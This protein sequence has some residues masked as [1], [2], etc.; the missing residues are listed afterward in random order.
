MW[1]RIATQGRIISRIEDLEKRLLELIQ[2]STVKFRGK[3]MLNFTTLNNFLTPDIYPYVNKIFPMRMGD[4]IA[5]FQPR[6]KTLYLP[7]QYE[8]DLFKALIHEFVHAI[9][10]QDIPNL[11]FQKVSFFDY[12]KPIDL[13][14]S[15]EYFLPTDYPRF[16]E[17]IINQYQKIKDDYY[18][19]CDNNKNLDN[20]ESLKQFPKSN[21]GLKY[22]HLFDSYKEPTEEQWELA[23]RISNRI[24]P[25]EDLYYATNEELLAY[26]ETAVQYF[27]KDNLIEVFKNY[28]NNPEQ[29]LNY[30]K[31]VIK[32][33]GFRK[34]ENKNITFIGPSNELKD[35]VEKIHLVSGENKLNVINRIIVP[36][37]WQQLAKNLNNVYFQLEKELK[38]GEFDEE[39]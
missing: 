7:I 34:E 35:L 27:S 30:F 19:F 12:T 38:Y 31:N 37:W 32:T 4:A 10:I 21:Y 9:H 24:S 14:Y 2:N 1:Y 3:K 39:D 5:G 33:I 18:R 13:G 22:S 15:F 26:F 8:K 36:K 16:V 25:V 28:Y 17:Y 20:T 6:K 23:K 29:F 11:P